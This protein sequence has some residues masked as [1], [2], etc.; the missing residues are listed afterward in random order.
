[1]SAVEPRRI[2]IGKVTG[3]FGVKGWVKI[4]SWTEPREKIIEYHPWLLELSGGWREWQV[5]EGHNHGKSLIAR[6]QDVE[7][8]EQAA[9]CIGANIAVHR[10]Q[11]AATKPGEYYWVDL[12]GLQVR[13]MDGRELG[14]VKDLLA[15][16]ANDVLVVQGVREH[17]IPFIR[18]R[19]IKDVDLDARVI[20]ADWDPEF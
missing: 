9:V 7:N 16:G 18:G 13:L 5:A 17:L 12:I 1:M 8:R 20:R 19:V 14:T 3:H 6:L 2:V 15:T 10:W 4:H 11:L